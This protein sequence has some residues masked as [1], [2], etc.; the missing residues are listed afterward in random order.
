[1]AENQKERYPEVERFRRSM[2]VPISAASREAPLA[3]GATPQRSP[4]VTST[5]SNTH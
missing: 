2:K 4:A 5:W 1:M 3:Y